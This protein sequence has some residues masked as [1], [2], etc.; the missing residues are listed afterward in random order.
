MNQLLKSVIAFLIAP[1]VPVTVFSFYLFGP[2]KAAQAFMLVLV[3][4]YAITVFVAVPLYLV[5]Y[6]NNW[7]KWWHFVLFGIVPAFSLDAAGFLLSLGGEGGMVT[8]RQ[9]G[10]DL[11]IEGKRT[12]AGYLF[13]AKRIAMYAAVGA[14]SGLVFWAIAHRPKSLTKSSSRPPS[15]AA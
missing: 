3:F 12:L 13:E 15:A 11:I 10:V 1:L 9:G 6:I 2:E 5:M 7:L 8:L 14:G 4:S